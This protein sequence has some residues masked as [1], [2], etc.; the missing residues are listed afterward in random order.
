MVYYAIVFFKEKMKYST[1]VLIAWVIRRGTHRLL[2]IQL[3][4]QSPDPCLDIP[5]ISCILDY[6]GAFQYSGINLQMQHVLLILFRV[7]IG[8]SYPG[9][10]AHIKYRFLVIITWNMFI[11]ASVVT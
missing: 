10:L 4:H 11:C 5:D 6:K 8:V 7:I 1:G 2:P 9:E 3:F